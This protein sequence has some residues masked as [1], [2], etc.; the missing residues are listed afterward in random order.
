[1]R[2]FPRQIDAPNAHYSPAQGNGFV[3]DGEQ[4]H[5]GREPDEDLKDDDL[6]GPDDNG[7]GDADGAIEQYGVTFSSCATDIE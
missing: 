5:D 3:T 4:E 6:D 2:P 7:V 1:M